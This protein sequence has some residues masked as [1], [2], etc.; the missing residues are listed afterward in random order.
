MTLSLLLSP[1]NVLFAGG[2]LTV[3]GPSEGISGVALLWDNTKPISYRIDAGP[4]SQLPNG[5]AVVMN[6]VPR[7]PR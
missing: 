6:N 4:L 5:G 3:G 1:G 2:P 7:R